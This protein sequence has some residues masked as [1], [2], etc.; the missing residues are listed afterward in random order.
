MIISNWLSSLSVFYAKILL[1][2][3]FACFDLDSKHVIG[4]DLVYLF[5]FRCKFTQKKKEEKTMQSNA[6]K[7]NAIFAVFR[8]KIR[9]EDKVALILTI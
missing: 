4:I 9:I 3:V 2:F 6:K 1:E 7:I 5:R 8:S